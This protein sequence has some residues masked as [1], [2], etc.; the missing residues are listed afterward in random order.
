MCLKRPVFVF[1]DTGR[2]GSWVFPAGMTSEREA[3]KGRWVSLSRALGGTR[4]S[5]APQGGEEKGPAIA[6]PLGISPWELAC[7]LHP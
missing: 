5:L 4:L 2:V 3:P 7:F 6:C 1:W